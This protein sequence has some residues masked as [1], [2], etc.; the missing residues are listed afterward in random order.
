MLLNL[1]YLGAYIRLQA[2]YA[3]DSMDDQLNQLKG[4]SRP[5]EVKKFTCIVQSKLA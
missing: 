1:L 2:D 3:L 4:E 5:N